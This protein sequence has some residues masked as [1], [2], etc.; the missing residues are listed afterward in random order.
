VFTNIAWQLF[1]NENE[2][3]YS[4]TDCGVN[5]LELCKKVTGEELHNAYEAKCGIENIINKEIDIF[6]LEYPCHSLNE[7]RWFIMRVT[8]YLSDIDFTIISHINITNRKL[9]EEKVTLINNQLTIIN[10]RLNATIYTIVHDIQAPLNSVEGLINLTKVEDKNEN[11]KSYFALIEDSIINLKTYIQDTLNISTVPSKI[12]IINFEDLL[13]N[14]YESIKYNEVLKFI[15]FKSS[16]TQEVKFY[17]NKMELNSIIL[18]IISNSLKFYDSKKTASFVNIDINVNESDARI[19]IKDNGIGIS[20]DFFSKIFDVN[21]QVNKN[22]KF[23][24]G[25]GLHLVQKTV[26]LLNG[27]I[28]VNSELGVGTEFIITIPNI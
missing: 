8:P 17:S 10:D 18:N 26:Q 19:S 4:K 25:I 16:I 23:G 14:I 9:S 13:N 6:E 3:N 2:G 27:D 11:I 20:K 22:P 21:F 1:S 15:D 24:S 12:E 5:Y 7:K 28:K